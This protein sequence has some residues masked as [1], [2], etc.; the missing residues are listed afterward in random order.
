MGK[1]KNKSIRP[2][3]TQEEYNILLGIRNQCESHE[4]SIKDVPHG[5]VKSKESSLFFRNPDYKA[6]SLD[7]FRAELLKEI[8]QHSPVEWIEE[9]RDKNAKHLLVIDPA[10]IHIGKLASSFETGED[11]NNQIA[12]QRVMEGVNG[13]INKSSGFDTEK[14]LFIGGNDVLHV[15]TP[16]RT[17]TSGTPQDTDGMWYDNFRLALALYIDVLFNLSKIAPVHFQF[18]PSNHDYMSGFFLCQALAAYLHANKDIT[19]DVDIKHR[20]YFRYYN[21]L[22][23][24]THGDG[25]KTT[26]LPLLM[27]HESEHWS[28]VKHRY[29]Y[30]HHL[31]HKHSYNL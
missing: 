7:A 3:I 16:R 4:L 30:T 5:W 25:A 26:D 19:F 15:D 17:T 13:I 21:N 20:K 8:K 31:Q 28:S 11:Y 1:N 24:S 10:D 12:V 22:I 18:N 2:R 23:G 29:F 14:I 9:K 6:P 27:A